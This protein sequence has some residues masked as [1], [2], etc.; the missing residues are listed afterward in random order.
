MSYQIRGVD[1]KPRTGMKLRRVFETYVVRRPVD[2]QEVGFCK[3]CDGREFRLP[4]YLTASYLNWKDVTTWFV[5]GPLICGAENL[6]SVRSL[7]TTQFYGH[8]NNASPN[9]YV[10]V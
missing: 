6:L 7:P 3:N 1:D 9:R 10:G 4:A 2:A 5:F 8:I